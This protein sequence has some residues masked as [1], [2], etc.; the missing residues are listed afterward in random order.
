MPWKKMRLRSDDVFVQVNND[1]EPLVKGGLV[2]IRY[3][4]DAVKAY[5]AAVRNLSESSDARILP[6]DHC[7]ALDPN[8]SAPLAAQQPAQR[9]TSKKIAGATQKTSPVVPE[10]TREDPPTE[11][12][13]LHTNSKNKVVAYAD[14]ACSGNPGPCGLGVVI[15]DG[16]RRIERS[17]YLGQ[18]TNNIGELTAIQRVL[19]AVQDPSRLV[20]IHTDSQY[21][22]G[23]LSK[24]WKPKKNQEL[25]AAIRSAMKGRPNVSLHYVPGHAGVALNERADELARLAVST[26]RT[27]ESIH[28]SKKGKAVPL[29]PAA[30]RSE[31]EGAN[32]ALPRPSVGRKDPSL[33]KASARPTRSGR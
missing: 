30:D 13:P 21:S 29:A 7:S 28:Q 15:L 4:P 25:I 5:H 33:T 32:A 8:V 2:E 3:R 17:E 18:G 24:G 27:T 6:D 19:D 12:E 22:I 11:P 20:A 14:G 16:D 10:S 31:N 23:V 26:R 1:G 9:P